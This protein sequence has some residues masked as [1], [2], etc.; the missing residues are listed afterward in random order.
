MYINIQQIVDKA[1]SDA[2]MRGKNDLAGELIE[3][4]KQGS[5]VSEWVKNREKIVDMCFDVQDKYLKHL[6]NEAGQSQ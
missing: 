5:G 3:I 4:S 1:I 2:Y 6:R